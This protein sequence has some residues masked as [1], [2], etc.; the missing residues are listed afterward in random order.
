MP[1]PEG[2]FIWYELMT[3]DHVAAKSFY[4]AVVGWNI[5][6]DSVAQGMEYRMIGIAGGG[7]AGGVM[8]LDEKMIAGGAR[9]LWIGYIHTPD[10]DAKVAAITADGG[11]VMMP[12]WDQPGVGRLAMVT[13]PPGAAFYLMDPLPPEG[14]EDATST[15]FS[16][17]Q[18][19]HVRWNE[20]W[21][22]NPAQAVEFYA[23]HF[24]WTQEG[25]MPMGEMGDYQFVQN[26][27]VGIGAI[28]P[29]MPDVP[30]PM[31]NF[32]IGVDDID[33]ANE[34]VKANGGTV[35]QEPMQIPGG[36]YSLNAAD[37][38]GATFGLVGPRKN[39]GE[40]A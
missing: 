15:V 20:L 5:A 28:M 38:Q 34:A 39:T 36:E 30:H 33:R 10:V 4:D 29:L 23:K 26:A 6:A 16:V 9:P 35:F 7:M 22:G 27:G 32:Y 12:P 17:D 37:P 8:T 1:N 40:N 25:G 18:P 13:D 19:Q 3:T 24:G 11:G 21:S 2:D 14:K 31:W